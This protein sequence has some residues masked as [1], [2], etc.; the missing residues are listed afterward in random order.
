MAVA[1]LLQVRM[2]IYF[3]PVAAI[4]AG[5]S[6]AWLTRLG[7]PIQRR[8]VAAALVALALA[9]NLPWAISQVGKDQGVDADWRLA[10][11]WLRQNSPEPFADPGTWSR[12]DARNSHAAAQWG[13][14]VWW[15]HGYA[16]EQI[17]RRIPMANGTQSGANG[18]ARFFTET[19][20]EAA[21][22][23]LR[24]AG[25]RYVIVDPTTP[26]FAGANRSRFPVQLQ[27]L[28]RSLS[29]YVQVL[30][31]RTSEGARPLPVYL[32]TYYQTMAARLYLAD[33]E[34]VAG[35]GPWVFETE[36]IRARDGKPG[37]LIL[38]G[39]HFASEA[40]AGVYLVEHSFARLT[41][42]CLDPGKSCVALPAVKGLK[43]VFSSD[44]LPVSAERTVRAVK[45]FQ[46]MPRD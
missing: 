9:A 22:G 24:R 6:C 36:R 8:A 46:V 44:P 16:V 15:E 10:L 13:V 4:L 3:L 20:P 37:E 30:V 28:G 25:A 14:A 18:M 2:V 45:I 35:F 26:L 31:Q 19:I 5:A 39:R 23:W 21:V 7:S 38:S 11:T 42:G 34:A 40:E 1:A 33:G 17:A 29:D 41:V 32:P 43:R 12:F 27:I